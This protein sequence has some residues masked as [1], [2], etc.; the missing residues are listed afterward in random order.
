MMI[1]NRFSLSWF[2]YFRCSNVR[3]EDTFDL[4]S[5]SGCAGVFLGIE[6]A[7]DTVLANMSKQASAAQYGRGIEQLNRRGIP[8]FASFIT[9]FPGET[10]ASVDRAIRFL[11]ETQPTFYRAEPF[12][13]NHRSPV[14][15]YADRFGL[16]GQGYRW[17]HDT[18]DV[19]GACAAVDH[20]FAEVKGS[21]WMPMYMFDFWA[22]PY[23]LGKGMNLQQICFFLKNSQR[24][25]PFNDQPRSVRAEAPNQLEELFEAMRLRPAKYFC[26]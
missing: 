18:M 25:L 10:D 17:S 13:Y 3:S 12:W 21:I 11:N 6:S 7:D 15:R 2:S 14:A 1:D 16:K 4:L 8:S 24:L 5:D 20:I 19:H 23:L 26:Q 22:L 9:G